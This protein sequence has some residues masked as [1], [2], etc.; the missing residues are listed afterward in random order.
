MCVCVLPWGT[1]NEFGLYKVIFFKFQWRCVCV[2]ALSLRDYKNEFVL[3]YPF[4]FCT[5]FP[6]SPL[7]SCTLLSP[8]RLSS[9][10]LQSPLS[11]FTRISPPSLSTLLSPSGLSFLLLHSPISLSSCTLLSPLALSSL[12]SHPVLSSLH[13]PL[14]LFS[15]TL[16][17][18]FSSCTLLSTFSSCILLLKSSHEWKLSYSHFCP[19]NFWTQ[20]VGLV[21][22]LHNSFSVQEGAPTQALLAHISLEELTWVEIELFTFL[23]D[24]LLDPNCGPRFRFA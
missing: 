24:Q 10:L 1:M 20:I 21:L 6:D 18:T 9:L 2:C 12:L 23:S 3:H 15:C 7:L 5:L 8:P 17:S 13:S 19:T 11:S 22:D 4:F 14:A 16:L